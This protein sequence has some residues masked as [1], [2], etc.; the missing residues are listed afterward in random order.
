MRNLFYKLWWGNKEDYEKLQR[1][2][3]I[4]DL[5]EAIELYAPNKDSDEFERGLYEGLLRAHGYI[6]EFFL[7]KKDNK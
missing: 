5:E 3:E 2:G 7:S 1:I 6:S 4:K